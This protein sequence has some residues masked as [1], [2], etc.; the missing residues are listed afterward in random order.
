[1]W[2]RKK[3][4]SSQPDREMILKGFPASLKEDV[5]AAFEILPTDHNITYRFEQVIKVDHLVHP[6]TDTVCVNGEVLEIPT[7][8]YFNE[9]AIEKEKQLS[10][11]QR[12]IVHCIYLRHHNGYV[13]QQ[14][15]QALV[16]QN[17]AFI[18]AYK[19]GLLGEYVVEILQDLE[20]HITA[21]NIDRFVAFARE[22]PK[23]FV[24]VE[25]KM[26]GSWNTH[27]RWK[28]RKLREYIGRKNVDTIKK[29]MHHV[30][31]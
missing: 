6:N 16:N 13:R 20:K 2:F 5:L 3:T 18:I 1:M 31:K 12:A 17:D 28:Y 19:F 21:E 11:V 7:R 4:N 14:R 15:L 30:L 25:S 8:V 27:Y 10:E 22:N 24:R 9:P 29:G 26:A 23:Y